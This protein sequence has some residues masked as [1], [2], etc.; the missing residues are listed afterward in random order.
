MG[1]IKAMCCGVVDRCEIL[2]LVIVLGWGNDIM[3]W[4]GVS[5]TFSSARTI[6]MN[7]FIFEVVRK[8]TSFFLSQKAVGVM[9]QRLTTPNCSVRICG[10]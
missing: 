7:M 10:H 1:R 3:R 8:R 2:A 9:E 5:G 4:Y 6:L